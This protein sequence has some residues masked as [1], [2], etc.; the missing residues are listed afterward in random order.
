[1][2]RVVVDGVSVNFG[3]IRRG[4]ITSVV[5]DETQFSSGDLV[6]VIG[7]EDNVSNAVD[8]LGRRSNTHLEYDR[9]EVDF[10]RILV[11]NAEVTERPLKAL[12]LIQRFDAVITRVRRGDIDVVPDADFELILGDRVRVLAAKSEMPK[13]EKLFGDSVRR[14]SEID[15]ITFGLGITAGLLLGSIQVPLT[16]HD[17]FSLGSAGGPLVMGL[18]LGRAGRRG[19]SCGRPPTASTSRYG[20]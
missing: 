13:L 7:T 17:T 4:G 1:M 19:H 12:H 2:V 15:V 8:A 5:H 14:L 16:G 11:S 18:C 9:S 6:T 10:R 3:R 20:S